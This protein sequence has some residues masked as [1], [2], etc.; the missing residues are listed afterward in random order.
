M[1][2]DAI[3]L[4]PRS[5]YIGIHRDISTAFEL[6]RDAQ[7]DA[8]ALNARVADAVGDDPF[9]TLVILPDGPDQQGRTEFL[10]RVISSA[11]SA[12]NWR[13]ELARVVQTAPVLAMPS[14]DTLD[15]F[16]AALPTF[17]SIDGWLDQIER[18][19][20][21]LSLQVGSAYDDF[22]LAGDIAQQLSPLLGYRH[23]TRDAGQGF[24]PPGPS[25][26]DVQAGYTG[27]A[28][29]F[30]DLFATTPARRRD[31]LKAAER[32]EAMPSRRQAQVYGWMLDANFEYFMGVGRIPSD[33][34]EEVA[35]V[36][37][38]LGALHQEIAAQ[39]MA[40]FS[41]MEAEMTA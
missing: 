28:S 2:S 34:P 40:E 14:F 30:V 20:A 33:L 9:S 21:A 36:A 8:G 15:S 39:L 29:L 22:R 25:D 4:H 16:A 12:E 1:D 35:R 11:G 10:Q 27:G 31:A 17:L 3:R 32:V 19:M 18:I 26:G 7:I 37:P 41:R 6:Y 23:Y 24:V 13:T 5:H 38:R